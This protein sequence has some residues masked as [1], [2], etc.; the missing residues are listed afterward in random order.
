MRI[1]ES[2]PIW[3]AQLSGSTARRLLGVDND[4]DSRQEVLVL[5]AGRRLPQT[6]VETVV[7]L[8]S[9]DGATVWSQYLAGTLEVPGLKLLETDLDGIPG[10]EFLVVSG[11]RISAMRSNDGVLLWSRQINVSDVDVVTHDGQRLPDTPN[12]PRA[13]SPKAV[14]CDSRVPW[15]NGWHRAQ[16]HSA[17]LARKCGR[18]IIFRTCRVRIA[19]GVMVRLVRGIHVWLSGGKAGLRPHS[20]AGVLFRAVTCRP[21]VLGNPPLRD[22]ATDC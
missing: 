5:G 6:P 8:L 1:G 10:G 11:G 21:V 22:S 7:Y 13:N 20:P 16:G 14:P 9:S 2:M 15:A 17:A 4:G 12:R 18:R 3:R 19:P